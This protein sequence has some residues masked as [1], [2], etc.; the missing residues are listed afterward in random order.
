MAHLIVK[1]FGAIK[2]AEIEIKKYNFLIGHT[3]SGKSTIAKLIA[4][5]NNKYFWAIKEGEFNLFWNLLEKYNINF[6][7]KDSTLIQYSNDKYHWEITK[8]NFK[9]DY[10]DADLMAVASYSDEDDFINKFIEK[11]GNEESLQ[12]VIKVIKEI[13]SDVIK[14][15]LLDSKFLKTLLLNLLY[16][17]CTPVYIPAERTLIS[18]FSNSIFSLLQA[19]ASIPDCIKDFGSLYEKARIQYE[20]VDIDFLNISVSFSNNGD[21]VY[22]KEDNTEL[23]LSQMSSGIQSIIPLWTVFNQYVKSREKKILVIEEPELNLFP[24]TQYKLIDWIMKEMKNSKGSIV[25]TTHSPYVL[26][27]VDNLLLANEI[28]KK[29]KNQSN[30]KIK[31]ISTKI[32]SLIP[33]MALV[34]FDNV[35]SYFFYFDGTVK[36][37]RDLELKSLGSEY[38]DEASSTLGTIFDELCNIDCHEL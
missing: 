33:S 10:G 35:S 18:T 11:K 32:R 29:T 13:N 30:K 23:K 21:T 20:S 22:L 2:S 19:G 16:E 25:I 34:D 17:K 36:D 26:S 37:I 7:F 5:F 28:L 1:D 4:I 24:S 31:S 27:T 6:N 8:N 15:D 14:K 38:I 3:S 12:G 9:S